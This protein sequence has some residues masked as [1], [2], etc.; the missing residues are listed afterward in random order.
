MHSELDLTHENLER[1]EA[2]RDRL[3]PALKLEREQR[4][5]TGRGRRRM[6]GSLVAD[7]QVELPEQ[8]K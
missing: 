2:E 3:T 6:R 5:E 7:H 8:A 4:G 1:A